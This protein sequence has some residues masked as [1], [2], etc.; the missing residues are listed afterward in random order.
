MGVP[1]EWGNASPESQGMDGA[2]LE[3]LWAD[4][5]ARRTTSLLVI[6]DD[7]IVCERYAPEWDADRRHYTASLAKALVGGMSLLVAMDDGRISP[8]DLACCYIPTWAGHPQ[9]SRITIRHLATH[10]SGIEDAET[11]GKGHFDQGG[12]KEAF[13]RREPDPFTIALEQA[14]VL[15][16]P[17]TAFAYSN[18]GMAAL[19]YAVTASLRGAPQADIRTL[20]EERILGPI[21]VGEDE[22]SIGYGTAYEVD[23]LR[24]YANWGGGEFAPRAVARVGRLMMRNGEWDGRQLVSPARVREVLAY[25]DMPL[26]DRS[27]GEP[28]PMSGLAWY[29]NADGVWPAVPRDAFSGSGAG[30]QA[31]VVVPSLGLIAVRNGERIDSSISHHGGIYR[32][33]LEPLFGAFR[34]QPAYPPSPVITA[35]QW[36]PASSVARLG[37]GGRTRDGSDNWPL[38]WTDD[39]H[40]YTAYGDGFGFDPIVPAKL[41]LGLGVVMGDPERGICGLNIRSDAENA[42]VGP[43]GRKA[44]S[45]L[46]VNGILYLWA[47]NADGAGRGSRLAWST[48]HARTWTWCDWWFP[49]LGYPS[50]IQYGR[51]YGGAR[52]RYVYVVSHDHPSAYEPADRFVLA[53]VP[54][55]RITERREYEFLRGLGQSGEPLWTADIDARGAV[56]A[57]PGA[58]CRSGI[59]YNTGLQRYLWWQQLPAMGEE[60]SGSAAVD[61]R[62]RGGFAVYDAPE[63]WG[64]WTTAYFTHR[65]DVGPGETASFPTKWMSADGRSVYLVFSGNDSFAVR[66]ATL[67]VANDQP[68]PSSPGAPR[69]AATTTSCPRPA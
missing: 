1:F 58:C 59:S 54:A 68:P 28:W 25:A 13:W 11:P 15:S 62:F 55:D 30:Q 4:L 66:Q 69:A 65:W 51:D 9:K 36:A 16:A 48:D 64:P 57:S 27:G 2:R 17:G 5:L 22:W 35:V 39:G 41:G 34:H 46:M 45:L 44:S 12:W 53:R 67:R 49:E 14:P 33:V 10:T 56:F 61:T 50:F 26:P 19:A 31:L 20:L 29:C 7:N 32:Y 8:D 3:A 38:T 40:L 37:M 42:D 21:G 63:P 52:D 47:R 24:L 60:R 43:A 23:G 18:P 6:R